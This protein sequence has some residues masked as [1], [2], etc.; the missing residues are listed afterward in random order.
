MKL[1]Y[2]VGT[3]SVVDIPVTHT[4]FSALTGGGKTEAILRCIDE[5]VQAGYDV[6]AIDAKS[7]PRD[8]EGLGHEIRPYISET[9]E[10]LL[11]LHMLESVAKVGLF[12]RFSTLLD[13][14]IDAKDLQEALD[15]LERIRD[16]K[17]R[18]PRKRD[19]AKILAYLMRRLVD[20]VRE[21]NYA[22]DITLADGVNVMDVSNLPLGV[23]ELVVDSVF[24]RLLEGKY[25]RTVVV[26]EEAIN[27]I[28]QAEQTQ[29]ETSARKFIRE[30]RSAQLYLWVSGQALTEMDIAVRKQMRV[31]VLGPQM[32]EREAEKFRKQVPMKGVTAQEIQKLPTGHFIAAIRRAEEEGG[33]VETLRVYAQPVWL[34]D[35][36]AVRISKGTASLKDAWAMKPKSKR[37]VTHV[38]DQ[39]RKKYEEQIERLK[40]ELAKAGLA[41]AKALEPYIEENQKLKQQMY[42]LKTKVQELEQIRLSALRSKTAVSSET[43]SKTTAQVDVEV[44]A[45]EVAAIVEPRILAKIPRGQVIEVPA[46]RVILSTFL[47][48]QVKR[49]T[50]SIMKLPDRGKKFLAYL[51]AKDDWVSTKQSY[52]ALFG[53]STDYTNVARA[54]ANTGA[55]EQDAHG[56]SRYCLPKKLKEDLQGQYEI[57]DQELAQIHAVLQHEFLGMLS[58]GSG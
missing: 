3:G 49:I 29:F 26:L 40:G 31:W 52:T 25:S 12:S 6:L 53:Y 11:V 24:R 36:V 18:N 7:K 16:D 33:R 2:E 38:D 34:P 15:T 45:E 56:R 39:E 5:A 46:K 58:G 32:E 48:G 14:C 4:V 21:G 1:G 9:T 57:S 22:P 13:A 27:F 43:V 42:E 35:E 10:P 44:L 30:G 47:E 50:E 55:I 54:I 28:P 41:G 20:Q 19:D 51:S 37:Q 23:Q 17:K 8:F